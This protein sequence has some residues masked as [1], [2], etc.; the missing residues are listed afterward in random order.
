MCQ[1]TVN[2]NFTLINHTSFFFK[3]ILKNTGLIDNIIYSVY[4]YH[5]ILKYKVIFLDHDDTSV[6]STPSI[7]YPAYKEVMKTLRPDIEPVSLE[8]WYLKNFD[9]GVMGYYVDE[10]KFTEEEAA[11]E[12]RI[13]RKHTDTGIPEFFP[14]IAEFLETY[15]EAGGKICITS[16]SEAV[17]IREF[18]RKKLHFSPD[19]IYGW[20][21]DPAKRKPS[22]WPV[23]DYLKDKSIPREET[24]VIDDL[25]PG[26]EMA[27][28]AGVPFCAACWAHN[29]GPIRSFM[30]NHADY[31]AAEVKDLNNIVFGLSGRFSS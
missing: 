5:V 18:Y 14:G 6:D 23:N 30:E 21:N 15:H 25:K 26:L 19:A 16:H 27:K 31:C 9:P 28:S 4:F 3:K 17:H 7:H 29:L 8:T 13:W 12:I 22:P 11:E 1:V 24:L 10:L 2:N 20:D